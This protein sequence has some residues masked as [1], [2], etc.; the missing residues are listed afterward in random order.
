MG[1]CHK[2]ALDWGMTNSLIAILGLELISFPDQDDVAPNVIPAADLYQQEALTVPPLQRP[3]IQPYIGFQADSVAFSFA[4]A[5]STFR[6]QTDNEQDVNALAWRIDARL[7]WLPASWVLGGSIAYADARLKIDDSIVAEA[8]PEVV[9]EP[10]VGQ[11]LKL[12]DTIRV[13]GRA[14][15]PVTIQSDQVQL[16]FGGALSVEFTR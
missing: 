9:L 14:R 4:P 8:F 16:G 12:R 3:S 5:L 13:V 2:D 6:G 11:Y 10:T 1:I 7:W 15:L